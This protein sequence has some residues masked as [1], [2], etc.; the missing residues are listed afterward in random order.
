MFIPHITSLRLQKNK[1][2]QVVLL[3]ADAWHMHTSAKFLK[4][5]AQNL[6]KVV[7]VEPVCCR[8]VELSGS[9]T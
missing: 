9:I 2:D 6:V 3:L 5:L 4:L 1:P 8:V 7:P